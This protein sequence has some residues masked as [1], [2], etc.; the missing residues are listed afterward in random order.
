[1]RYRDDE[2]GYIAPPDQKKIDEYERQEAERKAKEKAAYEA[3]LA[4]IKQDYSIFDKALSQVA[5][6][7]ASLADAV[8]LSKEAAEGK[9]PSQA[10]ALGRVQMDRAFRDSMAIAASAR[11]GALAQGM[12]MRQAQAQQGAQAMD[13]ANSTMAM[14]AAEMAQ[15]RGA[16][17]AGALGMGQ[18]DM[19][20]AQI[21]LGRVASQTAAD[22]YWRNL[23]Q[24]ERAMIQQGRLGQANID[25][26]IAMNNARLAVEQ[27]I[28]RSQ[29]ETAMIAG[30]MNLVGTGTTAAISSLSGGAGGKLR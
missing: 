8:R 2:D 11:G 19:G 21:G 25:A 26:Q 13:A 15:A 6:S 3:T 1:M 17:A 10:E 22:Q 14:R 7:R 29:Q 16:Y 27:Q 18:Q 28:A 5:Q 9:A 30:F 24:Q 20:L 23:Q 4:P 12:A